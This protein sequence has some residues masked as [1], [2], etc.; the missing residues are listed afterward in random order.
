ME[1]LKR[2]WPWFLVLGILSALGGIFA[3]VHPGIA[4]LAVV[5]WVAWMFMIY[6]VA[7]LIHA[8]TMK[9]WSGFLEAALLGVIALLLG[10]AILL[11]P[12]AG[13][14]SL[15][16]LVAVLFLVYGIV[17]VLIAFRIRGA[18]N[19][20]W[21]FLSGLISIL[22]AVL[23][24]TGFPWPGLALLGILLGVELLANGIALIFTGFALRSI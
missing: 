4:S 1:T 19:W 24:F 15:T 22:I 17:K 23:V 12:L 10:I 8:M 3:F 18:A 16:A 21:M 13:A 11:N 9:A 20:I 6:G 14:I 2:S 7:Q 5:Y